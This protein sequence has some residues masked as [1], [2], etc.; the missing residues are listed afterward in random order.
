MK[1][2]GMKVKGLKTH[3]HWQSGSK[4]E[5]GVVERGMWCRRDEENKV[6]G[7]KETAGVRRRGAGKAKGT[8]L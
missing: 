7:R 3:T 4:L 5:C 8:N 1:T 6:E 2:K